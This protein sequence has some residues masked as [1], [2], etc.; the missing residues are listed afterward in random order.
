MEPASSYSPDDLANRSTEDSLTT[1][2]GEPWPL[3]RLGEPFGH[4]DAVVTATGPPDP[5]LTAYHVEH[6]E[7][8]TPFGNLA[9]PADVSQELFDR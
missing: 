1:A 3:D 2:D 6:Y 8:G 9:N 7:P 5:V 4:A